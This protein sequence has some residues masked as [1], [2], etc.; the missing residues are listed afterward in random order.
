MAVNDCLNSSEE[1]Q[2]KALTVVL[3]KISNILE[4]EKEIAQAKIYNICTY[5]TRLNHENI[6]FRSMCRHGKTPIRMFICVARL[7]RLLCVDTSYI[8]QAF[9]SGSSQ[10]TELLT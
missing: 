9:V 1:S 5:F 3:L 2:K 10:Q 4:I 6:Q 8:G 7:R